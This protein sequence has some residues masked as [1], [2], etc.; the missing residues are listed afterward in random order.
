MTTPTEKPST[1]DDKEIFRHIREAFSSHNQDD[2]PLI[3]AIG[4]GAASGKSRLAK[5]ILERLI[6]LLEPGAVALLRGDFFLSRGLGL[7]PGDNWDGYQW[8][9]FEA[10]LRAIRNRVGVIIEEISWESGEILQE[11]TITSKV[12]I[13]LVEGP[14]IFQNEFDEHYDVGYWVQCPAGERL[15]R[16]RARSAA[17]PKVEGGNYGAEHYE[18][19]PRWID[20]DNRYEQKHRPTDRGIVKMIFYNDKVL[21]EDLMPV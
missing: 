15:R 11:I 19:W 21:G 4:G 6:Q 5:L 2:G 8:A 16:G 18:M 17:T 10:A 13:V 1:D 20:K 14:G 7:E 3:V 9:R 12:Q